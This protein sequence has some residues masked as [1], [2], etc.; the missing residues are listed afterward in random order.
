MNLIINRRLN[1][2]QEQAIYELTR[3][4][5]QSKKST[6]SERQLRARQQ[7]ANELKQ[8][9]KDQDEIWL[10]YNFNL[11]GDTGSYSLSSSTTSSEDNCSSLGGPHL[12]C[13]HPPHHHHHQQLQQHQQHHHP[14]S[15]RGEEEEVVVVVDDDHQGIQEAES[16]LETSVKVNRLRLD[17]LY[18]ELQ[19]R[20]EQYEY[21]LTQ[22]K[23]ILCTHQ[24]NT[25]SI[26]SQAL[27]RGPVFW[28]PRR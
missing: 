23:A 22:E 7:L 5:R 13:L 17:H 16:E 3:K 28:P 2:A 18:G 25:K 14:A 10:C 27:T 12:N 9:R 21:L 6:M 20:L 26:S 11:T 15:Q 8:Q 1:E 4:K 19:R 24:S